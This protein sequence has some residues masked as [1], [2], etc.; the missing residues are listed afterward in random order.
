MTH[1]LIS[2]LKNFWQGPAVVVQ[3]SDKKDQLGQGIPTTTIVVRNNRVL[4]RIM[5]N[6]SLGFGE[7]YMNGDIKIDGNLMDILK[8][9][10]KTSIGMED[11][12]PSRIRALTKVIPER[13][14]ADIAKR[15]ARHHY[16]LGNDFYRLWLDPQMVY[17]C[18]YY[19]RENDSL[20]RAQQQ[21]LELLCRKA[22]LRKGQ[23]LLDIGCGWGGL[24]FHAAEQY[25][26]QATGIT[27]AKEQAAY[28]REQAQK[29]GLEDR[30]HVIE[31]DWRQL[32][33]E[34]DRI[35]S[36]GMFEHV[37]KRQYPQ[38]FRKW[39]SLLKEDGL[40]L[41][42]TIGRMK[43]S[44]VTNP[45]VQK[46]IFPGGFLPSLGEI[47]VSAAQSGL[48]ATDVEN[49]WRHYAQTLHA[50][51]R[52][53]EK[54]QDHVER[55]YDRRFVRMWQLYLQGSEAGFRYG[56]LQLW[57]IVLTKGKRPEWPLN[58]EVEVK[59]IDKAL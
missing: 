10:Y 7:A 43:A 1:P 45:W 8:G 51:S 37:G 42:H 33:G 20:E 55:M 25:G 41:L 27:P 30:V 26:A 38:F 6:L 48:V 17:S 24:L 34:Y 2:Y 16:D 31:G 57:Q 46:Y 54:V 50:W 5:R 22:R 35:I 56:D 14:S 53:F 47:T 18:A 44:P 40:S 3:V 32:S 23:R 58:R 21:K 15:N 19:V 4:N 49:L 36:V 9:F 29:R 39:D 52:N 12:L 59:S 13:I 28:I 11:T